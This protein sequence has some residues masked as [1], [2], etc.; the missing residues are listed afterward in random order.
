MDKL[1]KDAFYL[2]LCE[3]PEELPEDM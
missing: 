2:L 3:E 1:S